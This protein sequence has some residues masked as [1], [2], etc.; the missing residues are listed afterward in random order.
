MAAAKSYR[1]S[2]GLVVQRNGDFIFNEAGT[3]YIP[4]SGT[5]HFCVNSQP[6]SAPLVAETVPSLLVVIDSEAQ[7]QLAQGAVGP[8]TFTDAGSQ[9]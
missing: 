3:A 8:A 4:Y 9:C 7:R 1:H 6:S 2:S 5:M